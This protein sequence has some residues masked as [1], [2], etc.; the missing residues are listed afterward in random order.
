MSPCMGQQV[1]RQSPWLQRA[2]V[3]PEADGQLRDGAVGWQGPGGGLGWPWV[4][5][6]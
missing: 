6:E 5:P 4:L 3:V 2:L 1:L